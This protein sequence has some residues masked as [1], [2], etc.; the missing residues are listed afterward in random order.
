MKGEATLRGEFQFT[1][2]ATERLQ[3]L[4]GITFEVL[5]LLLLMGISTEG[6]TSDIFKYFYE[7]LL[8]DLGHPVPL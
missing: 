3:Y 4:Q 5:S 6:P 1:D 8:E 2:L 7:H